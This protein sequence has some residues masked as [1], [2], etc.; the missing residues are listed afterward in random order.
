MKR[1]LSNLLLIAGFVALIYSLYLSYLH[2]APN[3]LAFSGNLT[4]KAEYYGPL[5]PERIIIKSIKLNLPIEIAQKKGNYWPTTH[6]GVSYLSST[7]IPGENGNSVLYGHNWT[8]IF[9]SL[10]KVKP[11]QTLEITYSNGKSKRFVIE[12]TAEVDPSQI[13]IINPTNDIRLTIYTCTGFLDSKRFVVVA[14]PADQQLVTSKQLTE[15]R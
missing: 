15:N 5:K 13:Q 10:P 11:G 7:P 12:N 2:F 14:K 1:F 9:G 8:S 6:N 3:R 4:Q